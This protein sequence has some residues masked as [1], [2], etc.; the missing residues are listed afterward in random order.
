MEDGVPKKLDYCRENKDVK[1]RFL[2]LTTAAGNTMIWTMLL[3]VTILVN[4]QMLCFPKSLWLNPSDVD[5]INARHCNMTL[6]AELGTEAE[7]PVNFSYPQSTTKTNRV[8]NDSSDS[9]DYHYFLFNLVIT[10][11]IFPL[12]VAT[13][14]WCPAH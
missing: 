11:L 10:G 9:G 14:T 5:L 7:Q 2:S 3:L 12:G 8:S 13:R 4:Q 6:V 1:T